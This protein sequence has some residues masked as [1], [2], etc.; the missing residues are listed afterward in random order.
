[1]LICEWERG[2]EILRSCIGGKGR[3]SACSNEL[4]V[5]V[6]VGGEIQCLHQLN[7]VCV[8]E[9]ETECLHSL[10]LRVC[11]LKGKTEYLHSLILCACVWEGKT[12]CLHSL[13]S[14]VCVREEIKG[15]QQLL[16]DVCM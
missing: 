7:Y 16:L 9:D 12:N 1:M 4:Y 6:C 2:T 14:C 5:C 11:V 15:L 13:L 10:I 3:P 8:W